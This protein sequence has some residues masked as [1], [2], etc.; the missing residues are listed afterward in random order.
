[1][2]YLE[3]I[4]H[5]FHFNAQDSIVCICRLSFCGA[6]KYSITHIHIWERWQLE[7]SM[8]NC[9]IQNSPCVYS[10]FCALY[11]SKSVP[12]YNIMWELASNINIVIF[13]ST[14]L[15]E[16]TLL[17]ALWTA[18]H[19]CKSE[20]TFNNKHVFCLRM[21]CSCTSRFSVQLVQWHAMI[22]SDICLC[23]DESWRNWL[24]GRN[25]SWFFISVPQYTVV[26]GVA[27]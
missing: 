7:R 10:I 19:N 6:L 16:D 8:Y 27:F 2:W 14:P 12:K 21:H 20:M 13:I 26:L 22:Q 4:F 1:M 23:Y 15:S 18:A 5:I 24:H 3:F 17:N 11:Y 9:L 25:S